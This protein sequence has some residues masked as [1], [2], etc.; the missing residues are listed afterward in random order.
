MCRSLTWP[1]WPW[2]SCRPGSPLS[3]QCS[4][5]HCKWWLRTFR[6]LL[7][8]CPSTGRHC[9]WCSVENSRKRKPS[10]AQ[11]C[12]WSGSKPHLKWKKTI[13]FIHF[14]KEWPFR[15]FFCWKNGLLACILDLEKRNIPNNSTKADWLHQF[16]SIHI[17]FDCQKLLSM[18]L[19]LRKGREEKVVANGFWLLGCSVWASK[20]SGG[21][22]KQF[23]GGVKN[24]GRH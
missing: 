3:S 8:W 14:K 10:A 24:L 1:A 11:D 9:S 17:R 19:L 13:R 16:L 20:P 18:S 23:S 12:V 22:E 5:G 6:S 4:R 7:W 15:I 2:V 21:N